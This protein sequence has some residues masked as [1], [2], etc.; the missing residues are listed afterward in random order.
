MVPEARS[1]VHPRRPPTIVAHMGQ[2]VPTSRPD[3]SMCARLTVVGAV[4][5]GLRVTLCHVLAVL[6]CAVVFGP[7]AVINLR[8]NVNPDHSRSTSG[9]LGTRCYRCSTPWCACLSWSGSLG[10]CGRSWG[11][12]SSGLGWS[13]RLSC[14]GRCGRSRIP[15]LHALMTAAC[16]R[17]FSCGGVCSILAL[18]SRSRWRLCKDAAGYKCTDGE[19]AEPKSHFHFR[20]TKNVYRGVY[21]TFVSAVENSTLRCSNGDGISGLVTRCRRSCRPV[22]VS[23]NRIMSWIDRWKWNL[24]ARGNVGGLSA[25][26]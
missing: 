1:A 13:S 21:V 20:L 7:C 26:R 15:R 10:R 11:S 6:G 14:G 16:S 24:E 25:N 18:P 8:R 3:V 12:L 23:Q 2:L 5:F 9:S 22:P 17:F 4:A 19:Q